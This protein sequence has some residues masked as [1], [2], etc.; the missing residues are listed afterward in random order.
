[1]SSLQRWQPLLLDDARRQRALEIVDAIA[2]DLVALQDP[3]AGRPLSS[4]AHGCSGEALF[5][6][7]CG[8]AFANDDASSTAV[9]LVE[10]DLAVAAAAPKSVSLYSGLTGVGWTI[11]HLDGWLLDLSEGDPADAL[12][13]TLLELVANAP[14]TGD[15]DLI[16]GLV[17]IGVYA[18]ERLRHPLAVE[19][20]VEVVRRLAEGARH[21]A[22]G[23]SWWTPP[24]RLAPHTRIRFP[25]GAY[26]LGVAHGVAGV[27]G[28]LARACSVDAVSPTA[29]ALLNDA[30]AW[31][32]SQR[33]PAST[34]TAFGSFVAPDQ[35]AQLA[36]SAWCYGDPGTA[37]ALLLAARAVGS[38]AWEATALEIA[39]LATARPLAD[40]GVVDAGL[41]HG[42]AGLAHV[43]NRLYQATGSS[44]LR[45]A[46]L[47]WFERV[48]EFC[49]PATGSG[50][51]SVS[52]PDGSFA[53]PGFLE[54]AAGIGLALLAAATPL[55]PRW[56]RLLLLS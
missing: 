48:F 41:C 29:R 51:F 42:A 7:Y 19:C 3:P 18:L 12:D 14:W 55:E 2:A 20:L 43:F 53:D 25:G 31:L 33:L 36:R 1:M 32:L 54:G 23:A 10:T 49:R 52:R 26:D 5:F 9:H 35:A 30:F 8:A 27:I 50:G 24:E 37:A 13:A 11:A 45:D 15:Y 16:N 38:A 34:G 22:C 39:R 47:Q 21:A 4:V 28:L 56:D 6:A 40:C 17:G 46:A 44:D